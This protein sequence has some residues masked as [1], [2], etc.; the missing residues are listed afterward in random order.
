MGATGWGRWAP[1]GADGGHWLGSLGGWVGSRAGASTPSRFLNGVSEVL[2]VAVRL[3]PPHP[4]PIPLPPSFARASVILTS[5]PPPA[6]LHPT[7]P[8]QAVALERYQSVRGSAPERL[9]SGSDDF[10]LVLWQLPP[11][12]A[13]QADGQAQ[14]QPQ[15][16]GQ[17]QTNSQEASQQQQQQ[18]VQRAKLTGHQQLVNHVAFS[19]DGRWLASASFDKSVKLWDG[20]SGKFIATFRAHVGPIYQIRSVLSVGCWADLVDSTASS[21]PSC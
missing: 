5:H 2:C 8:F 9:V 15:G 19:P 6:P 13:V 10:T 20:V 4:S 12:A 7:I 18:P 11:P 16:Q 17:A 21:D 1:E 14:A 3:C